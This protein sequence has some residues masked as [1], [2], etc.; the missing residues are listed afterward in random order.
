MNERQR[1]NRQQPISRS[2]R[3]LM[4]S[5]AALTTLTTAGAIYSLYKQNRESAQMD[6]LLNVTATA[7]TKQG[8]RDTF[9]PEGEFTQEIFDKIRGSVLPIQLLYKDGTSVGG[10]MWV[11]SQKPS[12]IEGYADYT[13]ATAAHVLTAGGKITD[14]Q[15]IQYAQPYDST[16]LENAQHISF[17]PNPH[18]TPLN[19][20]GI[21]RI[22]HLPRHFPVLAHQEKYVPKIGE[23]M[24]FTGYPKNYRKNGLSSALFEGFVGKV[25]QYDT[26]TGVWMMSG[27]SAEEASGSP[28]FTVQNGKSVAVGMYVDKY[29]DIFSQRTQLAITP[30]TLNSLIP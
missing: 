22:S 12:D 15:T 10:T 26:A 24:L 7:A 21:I 23:K 27:N 18:A 28:V 29:F 19:D 17:L 1:T 5:F 4:I 16:Y 25:E 8:R 14:I 13:F 20:E 3:R 11:V 2:R 6:S 30:L 9:T